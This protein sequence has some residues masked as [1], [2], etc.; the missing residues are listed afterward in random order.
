MA[1]LIGGERCNRP[2]TKWEVGDVQTI[3]I[4]EDVWLPFER[5]IGPANRNDPRVVAELI[6]HETKEWDMSRV[7]E[8]FKENVVKEILAQ[9]LSLH[10]R[11]DKLVWTA[12][13]SSSYTV[14]SSYNRIHNRAYLSTK[15]NPSS[16]C[17]VPK[18]IWNEIWKLPTSPKICFLLWHI[19]NNSLSTTE[20]L[21]KRQMIPDPTCQ[22]CGKAPETTEHLFLLCEWT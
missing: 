17:Q 16:S 6:D 13:S 18:L 9:P 12:N 11:S 5:L 1:K 14:K 22:I 3:S 2:A 15:H 20:N 10:P 21:Y 8:L 7:N 4:R 19:R